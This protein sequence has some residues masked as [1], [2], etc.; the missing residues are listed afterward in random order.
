MERIRRFWL[1]ESAT[2][3]ASSTVIMIAFVGLLL[4][5]GFAVYYGAIQTFFEGIAGTMDTLG[6]EWGSDLT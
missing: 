2:A 6:L 3:E 1:D 5:A 4:A